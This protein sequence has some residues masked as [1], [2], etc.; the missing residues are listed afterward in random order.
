M[1][2]RILYLPRAD[3]EAAGV[4]MPEINALSATFHAHGLGHARSA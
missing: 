2:H 3:V 1:K 4:T